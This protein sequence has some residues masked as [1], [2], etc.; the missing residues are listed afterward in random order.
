[1]RSN[2]GIIIERLSYVKE[3]TFTSLS[4]VQDRIDELSKEMNRLLEVKEQLEGAAELLRNSIVN[5]GDDD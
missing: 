2:Y 1:M 4:L 3:Y 5:L